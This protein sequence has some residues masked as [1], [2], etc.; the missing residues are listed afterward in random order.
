MRYSSNSPTEEE[1]KNITIKKF[2]KN[3]P[4]LILQGEIDT[5]CDTKYVISYAKMIRNAG[6]M[7]E[8]IIYKGIGHA[9]L[10]QGDA[11]TLNGES[12]GAPSIEAARWFERFGGYPTSDI[13]F[14]E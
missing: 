3:I 6:G 8:M 4:L 14:K 7:V 10:I 5:T 12:Y 9:E 11:G 1:C 2:R 13:V